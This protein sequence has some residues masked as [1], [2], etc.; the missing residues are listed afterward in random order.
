MNPRG[1]VVVEDAGAEFA[2]AHGP[3]I[4]ALEHVANQPIADHVLHELAAAGVQEVVIACSHERAQEI[5]EAL[6]PRSTTHGLRL[7]FVEPPGPVDLPE[8]LRLAAPLI[9]NAP[10]IV[11]LASGLLGE[12]LTPLLDALQE[13]SPDVVLI[14]HNQPT[15]DEHLSTST[16]D[17]LHIAELHPERVSLGMAG[18]WLFGPG[19]LQRIGDASWRFSAEVDLTAAAEQIA[20]AGGSFHV[21]LA[22]GWRNYRGNALDLLDL[23]QLALDRLQIAQRRAKN[24]RGV[25]GSGNRIEGRVR[26]HES[27]VVRDSVIVGPTVIGGGARITDAYIGPYTSVGAGACIEGAEIERSIIA[28]GASITHIGGRLVASVVGRE[29]RIFRDF[30]LPRALRLRVGDGTEVALC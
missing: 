11:H 21:R 22:D 7:Q 20:A 27:A 10:C 2:A 30:S 5:C 9:G 15:P 8:A 28:A 12:P 6:D 1:V 14:V 19:A 3:R 17:L 24:D 16:Q 23:N 29:A 13:G 4:T 25:N 18:V 26:I